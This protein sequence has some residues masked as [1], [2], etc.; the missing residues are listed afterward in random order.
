MQESPGRRGEKTRRE[1]EQGEVGAFVGALPRGEG[2]WGMGPDLCTSRLL[3]EKLPPREQPT[4]P[5]SGAW[6]RARLRKGL[7]GEKRQVKPC[8][9]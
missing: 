7:Q 6:L 3:K 1:R 9:C 2:A 4:H 5:A 8:L